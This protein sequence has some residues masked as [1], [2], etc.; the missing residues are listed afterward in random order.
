MD[1]ITTGGGGLKVIAVH[2]IQG[3]RSAWGPISEYLGD[4][5]HLILPN[6]RGRGDAKRGRGPE[7]FG[8]EKFAEDLSEVIDAF[9]GDEPFVLAG[10]SMG[11]SICLQYL[12][13]NSNRW[14]LGLILISGTPMLDKASWFREQGTQL[15]REVAEREVRLG[16]LE[17]ADRKAVAWTWKAICKSNQ[18][19]LLSSI[20]LP[21]LIINGK[22]DTD[23]PWSHAQL[24]AAGLPNSK[25]VGL[26]N[27]GHTVLK[28]ASID[29]AREMNKFLKVLVNKE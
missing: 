29:V 21:A 28:D 14:P 15:F 17:A 16:L 6:L 11:V 25:L 20:D 19:E 3:T 7:D 24:L 18:L 4:R 1:V 13:S 8:L 2:G 10:W 23:S 22:Q 12:S 27:V 26:D 5:V 9:V